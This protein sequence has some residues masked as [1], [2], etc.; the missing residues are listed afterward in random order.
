MLKNVFSMCLILLTALL[1]GCASIQDSIIDGAVSGVSK[2]AGEHAEQI[3]YKEMAPKEKLP[4][5]KTPGWGIFM[6]MQAQAAFSYTFSAGGMWLG[7]TGYKP[8]EW[9]KFE[10]RDKESEKPVV[11]ERAFLKRLDNGDEWW[12]VS[13]EGDGESWI[14]EA[15]IAK[16][17]GKLIRLRAKDTDGNEGEV[18]VGDQQIYNEPQK[19][20]PE[21][22][23]GATIGTE[24]IT[25]PA[26]TFTAKHVR[27]VNQGEGASDWWLNDGIPGGVVKYE[28]SSGDD[29]EWKSELKAKGSNASTIL[30]S[31]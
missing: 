15:L 6:T 5:P 20:S 14:Y 2:A 4:A 1:F 11:L 10:M 21:S 29:V 31:F 22:I 27:F 30:G 18:A 3:V 16:K 23:K 12:R 17:D 19:V 7:Q 28:V 24:K 9:T 13:W 8:G 26:G 25:V